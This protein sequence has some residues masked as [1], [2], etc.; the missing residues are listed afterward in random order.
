MGIA[1]D[2]VGIAAGAA[3]TDAAQKCRIVAER[4]GFEPTVRLPAQR[5]SRPPP[6]T[7]RPP[8]RRAPGPRVW[9]A[10]A[11]LFGRRAVA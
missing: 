10:C 9:L 8:L 2:S 3:G 11:A 1:L 7:T 4:V 5:L 6:S